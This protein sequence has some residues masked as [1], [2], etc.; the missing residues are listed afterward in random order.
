MKDRGELGQRQRVTCEGERAQNDNDGAESDCR[1]Q[2][3]AADE[4][5]KNHRD[6]ESYGPVRA[7]LRQ[8]RA[9]AW[10]DK[11]LEE[12]EQPNGNGCNL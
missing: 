9:Q 12:S 3:R 5:A 1:D 8:S 6:D 7:R 4:V 10:H 2:A 11:P